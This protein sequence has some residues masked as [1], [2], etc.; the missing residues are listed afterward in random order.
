MIFN[1]ITVG[2]A[3]D[4]KRINTCNTTF[5]IPDP[6]ARNLIRNITSVKSCREPKCAYKKYLCLHFNVQKKKLCAC[7]DV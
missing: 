4:L 7:D 5:I 3:W 6:D 2:L 1:N